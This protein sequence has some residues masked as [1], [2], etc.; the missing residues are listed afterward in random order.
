MA[1]ICWIWTNNFR[2]VMHINFT[3]LFLKARHFLLST[4]VA[5]TLSLSNVG[6]I[7]HPEFLAKSPLFFSM[8]HQC[9]IPLP[10]LE[11]FQICFQD[12]KYFRFLELFHIPNICCTL[13]DQAGIQI[14]LTGSTVIGMKSIHE[15]DEKRA[16]IHMTILMI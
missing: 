16:N 6:A 15:S 12:S 7:T 5:S 10:V 1:P 9:A 2:Y 13:S 3:F 14:G 8:K 4:N 11:N